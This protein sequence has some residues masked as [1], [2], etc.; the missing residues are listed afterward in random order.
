M[1]LMCHGAMAYAA[2]LCR[3]ACRAASPGCPDAA[4]HHQHEIR[5]PGGRMADGGSRIFFFLMKIKKS[6]GENE[7]LV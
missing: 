2:S 7:D 5:E 6:E 3:E 1:R 4:R